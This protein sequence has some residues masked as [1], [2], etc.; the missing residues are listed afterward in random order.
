[1]SLLLSSP[2]IIFKNRTTH[3]GGLALKDGVLRTLVENADLITVTIVDLSGVTILS[4]TGSP[5]ITIDDSG[6][7]ECIIPA[8]DLTNTA[9]PDHE[10]T[11]YIGILEGDSG[12]SLPVE[13]VNLRM[14]DFV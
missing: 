1:M 10:Y 14:E 5:A 9:F 12:E 8:T 11:L 3:I 2:L 6:H 7:F 4:Y 13:V